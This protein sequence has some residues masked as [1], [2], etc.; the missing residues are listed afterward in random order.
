MSIQRVFSFVLAESENNKIVSLTSKIVKL[1]LI[2]QFLQF[3]LI[4]FDVQ[5]DWNYMQKSRMMK[6]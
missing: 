3:D 6:L 2:V 5:F 4:C 1:I